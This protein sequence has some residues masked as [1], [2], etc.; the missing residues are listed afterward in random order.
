MLDLGCGDGLTGKALEKRRFNDVIGVD[1]SEL[2]LK[3][4][5]SRGCYRETMQVDL[6]KPLPFDEDTF[7]C[8]IST[9]VTSY[10][11]K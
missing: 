4:A 6:L 1:V 9:G 11:S 7:D 8:L 3:K 10:L 5:K 2:M